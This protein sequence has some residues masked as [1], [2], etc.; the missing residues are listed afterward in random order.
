MHS[1]TDKKK[2]KI[3]YLD[4]VNLTVSER[5]VIFEVNRYVKIIR[6]IYILRNMHFCK[7]V[8][9]SLKMIYL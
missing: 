3:Y 7:I 6:T 9:I 4:V 2:M 1:F 8:A 5:D